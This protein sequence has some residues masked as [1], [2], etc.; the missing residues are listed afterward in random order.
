MLIE[1]RDC[2][3]ISFKSFNLIYSSQQ[4]KFRYFGFFNKHTCTINLFYFSFSHAANE[5][6][7]EAFSLLD[8]DAIKYLIPHLGD[9]DQG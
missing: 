3:T 8:D 4:K 7:Y 1:C 2:L 5:I 6:D 9:S